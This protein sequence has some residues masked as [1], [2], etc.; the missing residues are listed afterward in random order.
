MR[1]C[2]TLV[3]LLLL[4]LAV[5]TLRADQTAPSE[6]SAGKTVAPA[7]AG[8]SFD[9]DVRPL[10]TETCQACHN[11][12]ALTAGLD[13]TPLLEPSSVL[14]RREIWERIVAKVQSGE[15]PPKGMPR[16]DAARVQAL[17]AYVDAEFDRADRATTPD[18]GRVTA[19]RLN[20]YEYVNTVRDLLGVELRAEDEL[21]ADDSGYGFDNI[22][23]VLT[24]SPALMQTYLA[25]GERVA[26]R[27]VGAAPLPKAGVFTRRSR[28]RRLDPSGV[29]LKE[30][31]EYDA[32]YVVRANV[33]GYRPRQDAPVTLVVSMDG[34]PVK[35]VAVPVGISA[36]NR[37]G[38]ATQ[39][40]VE[41]VRL[42]IPSGRH[43]FRAELVQDEGLQTVPEKDRL[44]DKQNIFPEAIDIAGP[45]PPDAPHEIRRPALLCNPASGQACTTRI[46]RT[47]ARRAYRRPV[48]TAEVTEL[49]DI[50][51]KARRHGYSPAESLQFGVTAMLVSPHFLYRIEHNPKAG[52]T[53]PVS[54][55][56]LASRL[57]YFLWASMPDEALLRLAEA[58]KLRA[59]GVLD[60]QVARMLADGKSVALADQF[61]GQWLETRSLDA[62][63]PDA[64]KFPEWNAELRD[65]M[66]M[67]TRL[68]FE[69]VVRE[70]RP[71]SD[72]IDGRYTFLNERLARHY[73]VPGVIG[74]DFRRVYLAGDRRSGVFT[75]GSV[76]TVSSYPTRTSP[77]LRGK[78]LLDNVLNAPPP[79]PPP[80]V[81]ALNEATTGVTQSLRKQMEQH[82][83]NPVCASCHARMDPLGF[84]LE[85]YDAIGRW[86][87]Q[88]GTFPIDASGEFPNGRA[89]SGPE[90]MKALLRENLD[91]FTGAVS[92]KLLTYALG[93]GLES[94]DR[95]AIRALVR[96]TKAQD[97]RMQAL[98]S[99]VV[100]SVPFQQRRGVAVTAAPAGATTQTTPKVLGPP[101]T[102]S[103]STAR[104]MRP[105]V[106]R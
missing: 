104:T 92:E 25:L 59:P 13:M 36:V 8:G 35:T 99:G 90:G 27:A 65:A 103:S 7:G 47:L 31:I 68:F 71:I 10:L 40:R 22:G 95:P 67:E 44:N 64:T 30:I 41:E 69:A 86:R 75:Q 106:T 42:F 58:R 93:R 70:N 77:V 52:M 94:Y 33:A 101:A 26:A 63:K 15:M 84:A 91:A 17:V 23:D 76:L 105:G 53:R 60:A 82:R 83:T 98:I 96:Q 78:Y 73:G 79:P 50:V 1:V 38:G 18:P 46:L 28:G 21:P 100:Q 12:T 80:G 49:A 81:P 14:T 4:A 72:F 45:Y 88:D 87:S 74:P 48:T 61:A 51:A 20:R 34:T 5:S 102:S 57:S 66:R 55:L 54:D 2:G 37:Q 97:Y 3:G 6:M 89:F 29:E 62:V 85:N 19:R 24:V 9:R 43:T 16:P 32:D 11:A 56:E 39:R